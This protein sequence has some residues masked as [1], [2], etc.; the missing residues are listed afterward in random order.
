[1]LFLLLFAFSVED[2]LPTA[3]P[4]VK[5]LTATGVPK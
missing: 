2:Q 5:W 3:F 4:R 1:V